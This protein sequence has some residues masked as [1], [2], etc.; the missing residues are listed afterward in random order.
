M[1]T[2]LAILGRLALAALFIL[3]GLNKLIDPSGTAELMEAQSPFPGSLA[4]GVG[5]FEIVAGLL[6][7]VGFMTR[8]TAFVLIGF[9]ALA[10]IFF[11]S[12]ITDPVQQALAVKNLAIMG[13]L[14]MVAAYAQLRSRI[15]VL[16]E[17]HGRH[18]AETRAAR[19]EG[20]AEGRADAHPAVHD[21]AR[22]TRPDDA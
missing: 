9:T 16:E 5:I 3:A 1:A 13:G 19:A 11:H 7:A 21:D 2:T 4:M 12:A 10:T 20:Q 6:L 14:A 8:L 15:K 22:A 18:D 17:R